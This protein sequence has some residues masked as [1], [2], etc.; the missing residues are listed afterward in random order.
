M[1]RIR[2]EQL[3]AFFL[4][5]GG[6]F[7]SRALA[8]VREAYPER[9]RELGDAAVRA[10]IDRCQERGWEHGIDEDDDLM[11]YLEAMYTLGF[12]F[13]ED[14]RYP[15]ARQILADVK[16]DVS[17]RAELLMMRAKQEPAAP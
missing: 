15:W 5:L 1:L 17:T 10:S 2:D 14:P 7:V 9:C 13:E 4:A 8:H 6:P 16:L 12:D 11:N 3:R